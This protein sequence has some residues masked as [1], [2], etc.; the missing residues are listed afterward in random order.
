MKSKKVIVLLRCSLLRYGVIALVVSW[1]AIANAA[2]TEIKGTGTTS[3]T[4]SLDVQNSAGTSIAYF[5]NDG[6]VGIG[7]TSP[8][9]RLHVK[10]AG[11]GTGKAFWVS[12]SANADRVVILDN[13]NVGIGTTAPLQK[14]YVSGGDIG[15]DAGQ[16]IYFK[17]AGVTE[18]SRI[19]SDGVTYV[20]L[21]SAVN[22]S[23]SFNIYADPVNLMDYSPRIN[24]T[25]GT[26]TNLVI[27]GNNGLVFDSGYDNGTAQYDFQS[28][29]S[30]KVK[31]D[32]S[33]NVGIGTT[34]PATNLDIRSTTYA[35]AHLKGAGASASA[36][37]LLGTP[38]SEWYLENRGL[39][40][41]PNHRFKIGN[42]TGEK[43]TILDGGNVGI[44]TTGPGGKLEVT[45]QY[46]S[47]KYTATTTID[48][49]NGNVQ[50]LTLGATNTIAWSNMKGGAVYTLLARQDATGGR[51]ITWPAT[52]KWPGGVA[53]VLTSTASAIDIFTFVSDG[54]NLLNIGFA[55]DVK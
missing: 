45:G 34:S 30:T 9:G 2:D 31:I 4:A 41:A 47:T 28:A 42:L 21:R 43:L 50:D 52:A 49:A 17:R 26:G 5:R 33:G 25:V 38:T 32:S 51:T 14:L 6:N 37:F 46:Y 7:T 24:A 27:T 20:A 54:T 8:S 39:L 40:D 36:M 1:P 3:A 55:A 48:W 35:Q 22:G 18:Y 29:G 12:D 16:G 11:T 19:I 15:V 10:G 13:G 53:P 23:G 44:G